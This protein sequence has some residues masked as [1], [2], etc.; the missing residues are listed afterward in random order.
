MDGINEAF[1]LQSGS[2]KRNAYWQTPCD[3]IEERAMSG[4]VTISFSFTHPERYCVMPKVKFMML[5]LGTPVTTCALYE[6]R[7]N[8]GNVLLLSIP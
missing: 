7:R 4:N 5:Q 3:T 6:K 2:V 1:E 8:R